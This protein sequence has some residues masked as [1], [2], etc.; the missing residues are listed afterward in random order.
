M[1]DGAIV[2]S[3]EGKVLT[4][5]L[6]RPEK[7]NAFGGTMREDLAQAIER[8]RAGF[9]DDSIRVIVIRGAGD[10]FC[11]GGDV[12]N[13]LRLREADDGAGLLELLGRGEHVVR[14]IRAFPGPVLAA[15]DGPAVGAG[16]TLALACDLR[17]A[18]DRS[19]FGMAFVRIAL[20]PDWGGTWLLAQ[21]VGPAR[22]KE[23]ALTGRLVDSAEAGAIGLVHQVVPANDWEDAV[24]LQARRLASAAPLTLALIK[25]S[26]DAIG[27]MSLDDAFVRERQAQHAAFHTEDAVEGFQA[28]LQKRRATY[29]GR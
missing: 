9:D 23:L 12:A 27:G 1:S 19:R 20:H 2:L 18:S 16:L 21:A 7:K 25:R 28:F 22:A 26:F 4:I 11:A 24:T 14:A 10:S 17:I 8:A 29:T 15:I 3:Q 13:L 5:T 6:D